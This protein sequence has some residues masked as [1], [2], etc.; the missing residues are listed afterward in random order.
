MNAPAS[1]NAVSP[2]ASLF[3]VLLENE[4]LIT[5]TASNEST[6]LERHGLAFTAVQSDED[7][8]VFYDW[9]DDQN[10]SLCGVE[11]HLD[12]DHPAREYLRGRPY[13][14]FAPYPRVVFRSAHE[15]RPRGVEAFGDIQFLQARSGEWALRLGTDLWLEEHDRMKLHRLS[16]DRQR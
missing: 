8:P 3:L 9:L 1:A 7:R 10:A 2:P 14:T 15:V 16:D 6:T 5:W 4:V 11:L 12:E 13:T